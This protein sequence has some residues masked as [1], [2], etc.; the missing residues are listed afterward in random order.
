M[1]LQ[2]RIKALAALGDHLDIFS[3]DEKLELAKKAKTY[4]PWFTESNVIHA[5]AGI[6]K[7]LKK[8]KLEQLT[9][10]YRF[11]DSNKIIG[12]VFAGNIPLV[13]F[14]DL[15]CVLLSGNKAMVKF[16]SKDEVLPTFMI[17]QMKEVCPELAEKIEIVERLK[18]FDA[19]IATG[20]NN[21]SRYFEYYFSKYPNIIRKNRTSIA[22]LTG[23]ETTDELEALTDDILLYFGLGCRN[24]SK[25]LVPEGYDF[26]PLFITL[27]KFQDIINHHKYS[28][29]YD[30]HK[31]IYLVNGEHFYDTGFIM[32]KEDEK[33]VSPLGVVFYEHYK[34]LSDA[35]SFIQESDENI[36]CIVASEKLNIKNAVE[37]GKAQLP[38]IDD[39]AD[40]V[41]TMKFL[42]SLET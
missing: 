11:S 39:F 20:S 32:F 23:K 3:H 2:E 22:V 37:P 14:H 26:E 1:Q 5:L 41:D 12:L 27:N 42:T 17:D 16:S 30:Y 21:T 10:S 38:E 34:E 36:Q 31:S 18:N 40:R 6:S 13:G 7:F 33:L 35:K 8:D 28:N 25:I 9:A 15:M 24:V 4:N 29:N 19:V